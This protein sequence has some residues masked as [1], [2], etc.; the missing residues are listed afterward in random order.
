MFNLQSLCLM[1]NC[2]CHRLPS[3]LLTVLLPFP[4]FPP[5][6][7]RSMA[8]AHPTRFHALALLSFR[9]SSSSHSRAHVLTRPDAFTRYNW[10]LHL[11]SL[12]E[13]NKVSTGDVTEVESQG[14]LALV[15]RGATAQEFSLA[16]TRADC[17]GMYIC[18]TIRLQIV[19]R[20]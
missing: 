18:T 17:D 16:V 2:I 4:R 13:E 15:P 8:A 6:R 7:I 12:S 3:L 14:L 5:N 10:T 9:E 1:F 19:A 11:H 20:L